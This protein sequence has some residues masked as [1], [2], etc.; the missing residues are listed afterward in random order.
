MKLRAEIIFPIFYNFR[1]KVTQKCN[2]SALI[3]LSFQISSSPFWLKCASSS[4]PN[5]RCVCIFINGS[6]VNIIF[7]R[8]FCM[9]ISKFSQYQKIW[10][11]NLQK[12]PKPP[13]I[14]S[15]Q[16]QSQY[17]P[18]NPKIS[19]IP[20]WNPK[21]QKNHQKYVLFKISWGFTNT[22]KIRKSDP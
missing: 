2:F 11:K 21:S 13:P 20:S 5:L 6:K 4:Q 8:F 14:F 15:C 9:I 10:I 16:G 3:S 12:L 17:N 19:K 18:K 7:S 1:L 22:L